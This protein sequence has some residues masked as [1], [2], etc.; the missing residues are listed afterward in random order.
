MTSCE[1][2]DLSKGKSQ[3][4]AG[5]VEAYAQTEFS[6]D[7]QPAFTLYIGQ[8]SAQLK[9]VMAQARVNTCLF[10]TACNPYSQSLTDGDN[11][12]RTKQLESDINQRGLKY[13]TGVGQ[14][15]SN[16]WP[17]EASFLVLGVSPDIANE[18]GQAYEQNA[19]VWSDAD[20]IARLWLLR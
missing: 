19:V 12:Q 8:C 10:I 16:E 7:A 4:P 17:G 9:Q 20:A 15:A 5:L 2:H 1:H 6:V 3:L 11:A 18:L 14:H 13:L